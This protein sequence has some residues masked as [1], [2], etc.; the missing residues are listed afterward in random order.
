[1]SGGVPRFYTNKAYDD[2]VE[3]GGGTLLTVNTY[4][5]IVWKELLETICD[6]VLLQGGQDINPKAY[7]C[8]PEIDTEECDGLRDSI[9]MSLITTALELN[10]PVLAICRGMQVLNV[11]TGGDLTQDLF[12]GQKDLHYEAYKGD[13]SRVV[14][15][16]V[17]EP[18]TTLW[19]AL[20]NV[21]G[22]MV[23]SMH[24]QAIKTLGNG[25][26]V[27]AKSEDGVI[28]AI[29]AKNHRFCVGVQWHPEELMKTEESQNLFRTFVYECSKSK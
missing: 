4:N 15:K 7:N 25:L 5:P 28:E 20:G 11:A 9:E 10:K 24:H 2:A 26:E 17:I 3:Y 6:G 21:V 12:G 29:Q 1:M 14:H 13:R 22:L 18:H 8:E 23:N 27:V 19:Y 16:L